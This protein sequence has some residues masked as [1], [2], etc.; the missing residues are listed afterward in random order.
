[1]SAT[2][3]EPGIP[4]PSRVTISDSAA[5]HE[6]DGQ[7]VLLDLERAFYYALDDVG[8]QV[9]RRLTEQPDPERVVAQL[10]TKYDVDEATLRRDL[11]GLFAELA[12]AGLIIVEAS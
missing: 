3:G 4:L 10:L 2:D 8:A 9:W 11:S 12:E 1:M 5:F 7:T 6:L